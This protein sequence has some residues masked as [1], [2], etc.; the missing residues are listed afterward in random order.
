MFQNNYITDHYFFKYW[1][2]KSFH[3]SLNLISKI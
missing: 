1:V 2:R 3:Q